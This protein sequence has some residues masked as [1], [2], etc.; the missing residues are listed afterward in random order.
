M[1]H[2]RFLA[3]NFIFLLCASMVRAHGS[4]VVP[5]TR[6]TECGSSLS[7]PPVK[8]D[9]PCD[10]CPHCLNAG[11][12]GNVAQY[13]KN[14]WIPYNPIRNFRSDHGLCGDPYQGPHNH[15]KKGKYGPKPSKP[16]AAVYR[17]GQTVEF[18]V[19][20]TANHDG[21]FEFYLCDVSKCGGDISERCFKEGKCRQ[22]RRAQTPEC[23]SWST[24]ECAPIDK[25]YPGRWYLP[26]RAGSPHGR[27]G[28]KYMRYKLPRNF[29]CKNCVLQWYWA[30]A[31]SCYPPGYLEY[32]QRNS[33]GVQKACG[34]TLGGRSQNL[35]K[36]GGGSF[37]EE[38]WMCADVRVKGRKAKW[39]RVIICEHERQRIFTAT[40]LEHVY[41]VN[42]SVM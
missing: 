14:K 17:R 23:E 37:P 6:G 2:L 41:L 12:V 9:V 11:G 33:N 35:R 20:L 29:K 28:G 31:N 26:C 4:C 5:R 18:S 15:M 16:F 39:V 8:S 32:F 25:I 38:Y 24:N 36:C 22:L 40:C 34:S 42:M 7:I 19:Q 3:L 21:F 30:T 27:F 13:A 10:Y 1:E